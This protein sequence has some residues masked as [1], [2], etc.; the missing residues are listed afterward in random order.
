MFFELSTPRGTTPRGHSGDRKE[1][2]MES[3]KIVEK[4]ISGSKAIDRMRKEVN[5]F[6]K[7]VAGFVTKEMGLFQE[8]N[9]EGTEG[10]YKWLIKADGDKDAKR[11]AHAYFFTQ[12]EE[13]DWFH[14]YS[15]FDSK[16]DIRS[17]EVQMVH[18]SLPL[19]IETVLK[20]FP[21]IGKQWQYLIKASEKQF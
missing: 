13:L 18:E 15:T 12:T 2:I 9:F 14:V 17:D 10:D 20:E 16:H 1:K 4:L 6:A 19:L 7:M 5:D 11:R 8:V 3:K 21:S